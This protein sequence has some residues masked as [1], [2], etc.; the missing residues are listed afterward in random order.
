MNADG[1]AG[2][3]LRV[4]AMMSFFDRLE[5]AAVSGWSRGAVYEAAVRRA[6]FATVTAF[7]P[8]ILTLLW[9]CAETG[10]RG[11]SSWSGSGVRCGQ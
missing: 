9:S 7:V 1:C 5:L 4:L 3:L 2:S 11:R 6:T 10:R 8:S